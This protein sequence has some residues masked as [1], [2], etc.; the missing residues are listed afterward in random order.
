[1]RQE[2]EYKRFIR[3]LVDG[4]Q[5][6]KAL[7]RLSLIFLL[8][9]ACIWA[10]NAQ[11]SANHTLTLSIGELAL[12]DI[13]PGASSVSLN[14]DIPTGAGAPVQLLSDNTIWLNYTSCVAQTSPDRIISVQL[15]S[16]A[17]P[18]GVS[19]QVT[20]SAPSGIGQG[21]LG[22]S[23]GAVLVTGTPANVLSGIRG[24]YTGNGTNNGSQL[25]YNL[26]FNSYQDL[27]AGDYGPFIISYTISN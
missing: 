22:I 19:L 9:M 24:C 15:S 13:E 21:A 16:G 25:T 10:L 5:L 20:A 3:H 2:M 18:A 6:E 23:A 17:L 1:M 7:L 11:T 8:A 12:L 26:V 27:E 4:P 14:M